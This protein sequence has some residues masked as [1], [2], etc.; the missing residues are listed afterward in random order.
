MKSVMRMFGWGH[1][2]YTIE[3]FVGVGGLTALMFPCA[4]L[5]LWR[6]LTPLA[7]S[8]NY[9]TTRGRGELMT[10]AGGTSKLTRRSR[11]ASARF[12]K[13]SVIPPVRHPR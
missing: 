6:D 5:R 10:G 11:S 4:M 7:T 12:S 1:D 3:T 2:N 9:A 8:K 13:S